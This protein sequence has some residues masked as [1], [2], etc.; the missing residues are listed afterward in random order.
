MYAPNSIML[1]FPMPDLKVVPNM[2]Q[3]VFFE[4][5]TQSLKCM[6]IFELVHAT[7]LPNPMLIHLYSFLLQVIVEKLKSMLY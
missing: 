6:G 4:Q 2:W 1:P 5:Q 3:L 7:T